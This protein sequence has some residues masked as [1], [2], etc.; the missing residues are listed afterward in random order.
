MSEASDE[1]SVAP[2]RIPSHGLQLT[3]GHGLQL[4]V[5]EGG[6]DLSV[7]EPEASTLL[8]ELAGAGVRE[9]VIRQAQPHGPASVVRAAH[10]VM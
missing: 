2:M 10:H 3:V 8:H 5:R 7:L 9:Q 6:I 4:T 1:L